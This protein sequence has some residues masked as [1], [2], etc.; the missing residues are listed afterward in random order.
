MKTSQPNIRPFFWEKYSIHEL[1]QA[2]WEALCDGCGICCLVKLQDED[3]NEVIYTKL[4]CQL[5]DCQTGHCQDYNNRKRLV[6]DCQQL[7]PTLL[8]QSDWLP[9]T[10]GYRRLYEKKPLPTWHPLLTGT[11]KTV[12]QAG[13][14]VA[15]RCRS[16]KGIEADDWEEYVIKWVK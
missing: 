15:G 3:T 6:P 14:S 5:L 8:K 2:E 1:S 7:T 16:E 9:S 10:C 4:A 13:Q 11:D 12:K